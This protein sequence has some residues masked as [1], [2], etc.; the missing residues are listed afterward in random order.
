M[1]WA[2]KQ[3]W[4]FYSLQVH[5]GL[6]SLW[7]KKENG[8]IGGKLHL[9]P[10]RQLPGQLLWQLTLFNPLQQLQ[11][12]QVHHSDSQ[13]NFAD[14]AWHD[15]DWVWNSLNSFSACTCTETPR[16]INS[17]WTLLNLTDIDNF[18]LRSTH[19]LICVIS[20]PGFL[21]D[22][23]WYIH[24][25]PSTCMAIHLIW[26][27]YTREN[28]LIKMFIVAAKKDHSRVHLW[29]ATMASHVIRRLQCIPCHRESQHRCTNKSF[30]SGTHK[31]ASKGKCSEF[32]HLTNRKQK[33]R[34][35]RPLGP[36][37]H[38]KMKFHNIQIVGE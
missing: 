4:A 7:V 5:I 22:L 31:H 33:C 17:H 32:N 1:L 9:R 16:F 12:E 18:V 13:T 10:T 6:V 28:V 14:S 19:W 30:R 15:L 35:T 27:S 38:L 11:D 36:W 3:A 23:P 25:H 2:S 37:K 8:E 29:Y 24:L 20:K 34:I 26:H 21:I